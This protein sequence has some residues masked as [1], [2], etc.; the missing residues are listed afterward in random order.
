[1]KRNF[2]FKTYC[3][4]LLSATLAHAQTHETGEKPSSKKEKTENRPLL[5]L[6]LNVSNAIANAVGSKGNA[7]FLSY[8]DPYQLNL[9]RF[10]PKNNQ[11]I[12]LGLG[13]NFNS[14][15]EVRL[16]TGLVRVKSES[17]ISA[18]IGYEWRKQISGEFLYTYGVD[19]AVNYWYNSSQVAFASELTDININ[20]LLIG[21]GGSLGVRW[22]HKNGRIAIGTEALL[23]V[24]TGSEKRKV[25]DKK[26]GVLENS[27]KNM[28]SLSNFL[29]QSL[30][31]IFRF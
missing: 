31:F 28:T 12:R 18:R 22:Q 19:A 11:A 14:S 2:I 24:T 6:G 20:Q 26:L 1:M 29:P 13:W 23:Y 25:V 15:K 5:E 17:P 8:Q 4:F 7:D 10:N 3:V 21:G 16:T 30:Y 9:W 27:S